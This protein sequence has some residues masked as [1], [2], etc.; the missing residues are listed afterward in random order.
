[1]VAAPPGPSRRGCIRL[2][3]D[4]GTQGKGAGV[5]MECA[6]ELGTRDERL[7]EVLGAGRV[8]QDEGPAPAPG[9]A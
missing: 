7:L 3:P 1:M 4:Q 5:K 6:V 2:L 8:V 9:A